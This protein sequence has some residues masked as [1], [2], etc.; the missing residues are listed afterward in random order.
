M[1]I[2]NKRLYLPALFIIAVVI[3]LLVITGISTYQHFSMAEKR[4]ES[5]MRRQAAMLLKALE[6]GA[7]SAMGTPMRKTDE[8]GRLFVEAAKDPSIAMIYLIG[9]DGKTL[10]HANW[11]SGNGAAPWVPVFTETTQKPCEMIRSADGDTIF[12]MG[13]EF[14]PQPLDMASSRHFKKHLDTTLVVGLSMGEYEAARKLDIRHAI[15]MGGIMV[16]LGA[17]ALFFLFVIQNYTLVGH[18]LRQSREDTREVI[19]NMADGLIAID[20]RRRLLFLN[21]QAAGLLG[22]EKAPSPGADLTPHLAFEAIGVQA[23]LEEGTKTLNQEILLEKDKGAILPLSFNVTPLREQDGSIRGAV[24]LIRDLTELRSL[25]IQMRR[26]ETLAA[27]GA[28]A[29][30]VAHEIRNP[31]SSIRTGVQFLVRHMDPGNPDHQYSQLIISEVDRISR[32]VADLL[33]FSRPSAPNRAPED[34]V[35]LCKHSLQ[36]VQ[37]EAAANGVTLNLHL[38]NE[39]LIIDVDRHQMIQVLLNLLLN[40]LAASD[41]E[42]RIDVT[43][44]MNTVDQCAEIAIHDTGSGISPSMMDKLFVPFF[45]TREQG[46]GL[47]LAIALKIVEGHLGKIHVESPVPGSDRGSSFTV[48]L[49]TTIRLQSIGGDL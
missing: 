11:Q 19:L 22:I 33:S 9:N 10:H 49:P 1:R 21:P 42:G 15:F 14:K 32:V 35:A 2:S 12:F 46:T 23:A 45:T 20:E 18:A 31:L 41:R 37:A 17:G 44:S 3:V 24:V 7:R 6:A 48:C 29:A 4:A 27:V 40:A 43:V 13:K 36:L 47:G 8:L 5:T 39:E 34:L 28:L 25:E 16:S 30:S 38:E 26:A